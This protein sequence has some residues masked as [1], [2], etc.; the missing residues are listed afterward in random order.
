MD[1]WLKPRG[2]LVYDQHGQFVGGVEREQDLRSPRFTQV[3]KVTTVEV[4]TREQIE[5]MY[6]SWKTSDST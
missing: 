2:L 3:G 4:W 1:G 5:L 6:K